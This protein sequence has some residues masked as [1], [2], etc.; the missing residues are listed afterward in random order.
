[1]Q[2]F[3]RQIDVGNTNNMHSSLLNGTN[4]SN[5][6]PDL[7]SAEFDPSIGRSSIMQSI[8][9]DMLDFDHDYIGQDFHDQMES[10]LNAV[11]SEFPTALTE[12]TATDFPVVLR[13][14]SIPSI[15]DGH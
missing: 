7:L 9:D 1:M 6:P 8:I 2:S 5:Q 10:D 15:P 12:D 4:N 13:R 3:N 14:M 11:Y